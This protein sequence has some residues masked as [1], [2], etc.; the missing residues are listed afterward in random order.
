MRVSDE[1]ISLPQ[2]IDLPCFPLRAAVFIC[3]KS[4]FAVRFNL[5]V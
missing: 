4:L 2:T 5:C 1:D 3:L